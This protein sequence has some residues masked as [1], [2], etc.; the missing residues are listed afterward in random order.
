[1]HDSTRPVRSV[2]DNVWDLTTRPAAYTAIADSEPPSRPST[3]PGRFAEQLST[4]GIV[5][6]ADG[7]IIGDNQAFTVVEASDGG[8]RQRFILHTRT[9]ND[10]M[11]AAGYEAD[12]PLQHA[13]RYV[14][15]VLTSCAS[16]RDLR[17]SFY[18]IELPPRARKYFRFADDSGQTWQ[19]R[20]LPMGFTCAPELM[21]SITATLGMSPGYSARTVPADV[22]S[23]IFVDNIRLSGSQGQVCRATQSVDERA[24]LCGVAWKQS[25]SRDTAQKYCFLGVEYDHSART[26]RLKSEFVQKLRNFAETMSCQGTVT[27]GELESYVGRMVHACAV[28]NIPLG[29]YYFILKYSRRVQSKLNRGI[30]GPDAVLTLPPS[31]VRNVRRINGAFAQTRVVSPPHPRG[32]ERYTVYTDASLEG[33]GVVVERESDRQLSVFGGKWDDSAHINVLEARVLQILASIC[34]SFPDMTSLDVYVDNTTVAYAARKS[35]CLRN[36]EINDCIVSFLDWVRARN[37]A[38]RIF[39]VASGANPADPPSR[40]TTDGVVERLQLAES[41]IGATKPITR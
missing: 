29:R 21:H 25:D 12:V 3:F 8:Q 36:G 37:L 35:L 32:A 22:T 1:V 40:G 6:R 38:H 14:P 41:D 18:Q 2:A 7:A 27:A 39:W 16:T 23:D 30:I 24:A 26:V 28:L 4:V 17:T 5:E 10:G 34:D 33:W 19:M 13:S 9:L 15:A 31:F 11:S 20:R